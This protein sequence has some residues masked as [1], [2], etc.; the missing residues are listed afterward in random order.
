VEILT[1]IL[2]LLDRVV[3]RLQNEIS[4][5]RLRLEEKRRKRI[6]RQEYLPRKGMLKLGWNHFRMIGMRYWSEIL[7][8]SKSKEHFCNRK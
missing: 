1:T 4:Y 3:T 8:E 2:R 7:L 5:R 6:L